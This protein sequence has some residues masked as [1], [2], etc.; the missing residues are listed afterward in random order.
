M[1]GD[2]PVFAR[3]FATVDFW[4]NKHRQ[5]WNECEEKQSIILEIDSELTRTKKELLKITHGLNSSMGQ[6][7]NGSTVLE[8][9]G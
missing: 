5:A 8:P 4:R 7:M 1:H 6:T 2:D 9:K 3:F